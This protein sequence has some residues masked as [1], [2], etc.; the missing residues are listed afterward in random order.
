MHVHT[1]DERLIF[2]MSLRIKMHRKNM[3]FSRSTELRAARFLLCFAIIDD[4]CAMNS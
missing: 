2:E 1:V 3:H 4:V